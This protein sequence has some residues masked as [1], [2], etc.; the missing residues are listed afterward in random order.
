MQLECGIFIRTVE[1]RFYPG[2]LDVAVAVGGQVYVAE[3]AGHAPHVL[4]LQIGAV[5]ILEHLHG[6]HVVAAAYEVSDVK[7]RRHVRHLGE[8]CDVAVNPHIKGRVHPLKSDVYAVIDPVFRQAEVF[9]V[10]AYGVFVR[11]KGRVIGDG[12]VHIGIDRDVIAFHLPTGRNGQIVPIGVVIIDFPEVAGQYIRPVSEK[13]APYAVQRQVAAGA[14][15]AV[16]FGG[17]HAVI[18]EKCRVGGQTPFLQHL[19][20]LVIG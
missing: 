9:A 5:G 15:A 3:D 19:R 2:V 16:G 17:F 8:A 20:V 6:E 13:E 7:L 12:V 4:I 10:A 18:G 1:D 14:S 11:H